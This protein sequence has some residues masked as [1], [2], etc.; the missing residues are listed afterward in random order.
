MAPGVRSSKSQIVG[1]SQDAA[2]SPNKGVAV[3]RPLPQ[4]K[5]YHMRMKSAYKGVGGG[6]KPEAGRCG[7]LIQQV[8]P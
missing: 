5:S 8:S 3:C 2:H 1:F 6:G 4:L 7:E